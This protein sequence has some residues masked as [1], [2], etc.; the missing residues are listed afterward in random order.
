[1][2]CLVRKLLI[3]ET[4]PVYQS[5]VSKPTRTQQTSPLALAGTVVTAPTAGLVEVIVF[6][7][8]N[9]VLVRFMRMRTRLPWVFDEIANSEF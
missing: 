2:S 4:I 5:R 8:F 7:R 1:M 6:V 9:V 3:P